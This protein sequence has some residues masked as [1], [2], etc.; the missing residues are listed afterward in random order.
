[1]K[2]LVIGGIYQHYKGSRI[3]VLAEALHSETLEEMVVYLHLE[4][5]VIWVRPKG[6]FLEN[7]K[8]NRRSMERFKLIKSKILIRPKSK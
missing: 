2:K 8:V 3:K 4:D 6:M 1:M 7:V 5:G